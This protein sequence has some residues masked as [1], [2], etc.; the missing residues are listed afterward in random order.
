MKK[1]LIALAVVSAFAAQSASADTVTV[2]GQAN[3]SYD[4]VNSGQVSSATNVGSVSTNHVTSNN[5]RLDFKGAED[6]G[7]GVS[8]I[9]Q[10]DERLNF[11]SSGAT[12]T[13]G[14]DSAANYS[15]STVTVTT[16]DTF[17]GLSSGTYGTAIIGIHDTPYK[18]AGRG[19]DLF[20]D[21]IADNRGI[22]GTN[23]IPGVGAAT[24]GDLRLNNVVAYISPAMSGLTL[25]IATISGADIPVQ[26]PANATT[27][28]SA[29]SMA[30]LY[31]AGPLTANFAYQTITVGAAG[32]GTL[33]SANVLGLAANDKTTAWRLGGSYAIDAWKIVGELEHQSATTSDFAALNGGDI[34]NRSA[35]YLGT[36]YKVSASDA[37]KAAYTHAGET[38]NIA[39]TGATQFSVGYD[40]GL[41]K[42]TTVYALYTKISNSSASGYTFSQGTST[43]GAPS[44][45]GTAFQGQDPSAFSIGMKHAF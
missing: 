8:A 39:N 45:A 12:S 20:Y 18:M 26:N 17:A 2:F 35:W 37:V 11:V 23:Y 16:G 29:W 27:K 9:W 41:S 36:Q 7:D 19:Y 42:T 22:M 21:V 28:G 31:G 43:N 15:G 40:H 3:V 10:I 34:L 25:A 1:S 30:A 13:G 38:A 4:V 33:Q 32:T 5:S 6:L 24:V 44:G 14:A